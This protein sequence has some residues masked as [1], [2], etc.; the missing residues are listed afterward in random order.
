MN[1][2]PLSY[3]DYGPFQHKFQSQTLKVYGVIYWYI[4][5]ATLRSP[6]KRY[7]LED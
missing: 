1:R 7:T 3:H 4:Y 2:V 5:M 6:A